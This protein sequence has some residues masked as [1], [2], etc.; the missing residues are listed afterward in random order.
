MF[1]SAVSAVAS[2]LPDELKSEAKKRMNRWKGISEEEALVREATNDDKWGPHG[3]QLK[4]IARLT[5]RGHW[6]VVWDVLRER[7]ALEGERW[8]QTYKALSVVEYLVANGDERIPDVVARSR[9][10]DRLMRFEY[11]DAKGKDEGVNVRHRAEK[12]K[13]LIEDPVAIR[14]ARERA[15]RNRGKYAG[16]SS[17]DARHASERSGS[18]G[19][20]YSSDGG[21]SR[22]AS[23]SESAG[24]REAERRSETSAGGSQWDHVRTP[25]ST[26]FS[27]PP[28]QEVHRTT[29]QQSVSIEASRKAADSSDDEAEVPTKAT[30]APKIIFRDASA[31]PPPARAPGVLSFAPPPR[32]SN[33]AV[34]AVNYSSAATVA[35]QASTATPSIDDLLGSLSGPTAS[36]AAPPVPA[37]AATS[38]WGDLDGLFSAP[39]ARAPAPP[40]QADPFA[41]FGA[42]PTAP[43]VP[44]NQFGFAAPPAPAHSSFS[45]PNVVQQPAQQSADPF[46]LASFGSP[47]AAH[48]PAPRS[49]QKQGPLDD[50]AAL[51]ADLG[52]GGPRTD[53]QRANAPMSPFGGSLI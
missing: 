1:K 7:L 6:E 24:P 35:P 37:A 11:R 41:S 48:P 2:A 17:A 19:A 10:M 47:S 3:E 25:S 13:A 27:A 40:Q 5:T 15:E 26:S 21:H 30:A 14:E 12:I 46:G 36:I 39:A 43:Q 9:V 34:M 32:A 4:E 44:A 31:P 45:A 51:T 50:L 22:S 29:S 38:T 42:A 49:P 16:M 23:V 18:T 28:V 53:S 20:A 8:R 52:L 33:A